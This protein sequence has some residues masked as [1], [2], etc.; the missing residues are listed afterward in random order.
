MATN[1]KCFIVA[2]LAENVFSF[3]KVFGKTSEVNLNNKK[4]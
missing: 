4:K 3:F 1:I 2:K